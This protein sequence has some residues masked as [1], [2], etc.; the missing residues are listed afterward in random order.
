[1][2]F[3]DETIVFD[4][5][6]EGVEVETQ[7]PNVSLLGNGGG[8]SGGALPDTSNLSPEQL[9]ELAPAAGGPGTGGAATS[10]MVCG[11]SFLGGDDCEDEFAQ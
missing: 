10:N 8:S 4:E 2:S 5:P 6:F 11:N 9:G 3:A 7:N 1:M